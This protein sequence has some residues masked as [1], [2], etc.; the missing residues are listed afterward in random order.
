MPETLIGVEC[1]FCSCL[2]DVLYS[3]KVQYF[4]SFF[5]FLDIHVQRVHF[6]CAR[7]EDQAWQIQGV[8]V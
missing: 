4:S 3:K 5:I 1:V 8:K 6:R 7:L 2:L